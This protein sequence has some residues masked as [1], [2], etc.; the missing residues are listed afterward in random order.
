MFTWVL[1]VSKQWKVALLSANCVDDSAFASFGEQV[2]ETMQNCF[3]KILIGNLSTRLEKSSLHLSR[4]PL[5]LQWNR[6]KKR[7][8][9]NADHIH[10]IAQPYGDLKKVNR[11]KSGGICS[12]LHTFNYYST[13]VGGKT[14]QQLHRPVTAVSCCCSWTPT[15]LRTVQMYMVYGC[16]V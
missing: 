14:Q 8:E 9:P 16:R 5:I 1:L 12:I 6:I 13:G 4:K 11:D 3:P 10:F 7:T 2:G 15:G